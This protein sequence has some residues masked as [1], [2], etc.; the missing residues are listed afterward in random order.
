MINPIIGH[1]ARRC[2]A[3]RTFG[4]FLSCFLYLTRDEAVVILAMKM[5]L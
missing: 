4:M 5:S 1:L 3:G 2:G